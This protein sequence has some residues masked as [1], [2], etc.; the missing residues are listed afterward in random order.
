VLAARAAMALLALHTGSVDDVL[1]VG[2]L[3][4]MPWSGPAPEVGINMHGKGPQSHRVTLATHPERLLSFRH[5]A[6]PNSTSG[7]EWREGER[8]VDRWCRLLRAFGIPA[9][10]TELDLRAPPGAPSDAR[11]AT[12]VHPGA[13]YPARRWPA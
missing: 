7:P 6:V 13:A 9:H 2:E 10:P 5:N 11:G 4:P 3:A 12:L 1:V 8:E